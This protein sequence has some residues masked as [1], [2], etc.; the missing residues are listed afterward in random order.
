M[1]QMPRMMRASGAEFDAMFL[2]DMIPHH[3]SGIEMARR[4]LPN[5]HRPELRTLATAIQTTQAREIEEM[6]RMRDSAHR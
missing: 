4:A 3:A 6:T 5:L 1:A 2:T